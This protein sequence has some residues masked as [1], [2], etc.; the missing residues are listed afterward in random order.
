[1]IHLTVAAPLGIDSIFFSF[2]Q[3]LAEQNGH[4]C[5]NPPAQQLDEREPGAWIEAMKNSRQHHFVIGYRYPPAYWRT[6][7][8]SASTVCLLADPDGIARQVQQIHQAG[9]GAENAGD[10]RGSVLA[11]G[12]ALEATIGLAEW[13]LA[14]KESQTR[15]LPPASSFLAH[16]TAAFVR[17][18]QFYQQASIKI[19]TPCAESFSAEALPLLEQIQAASGDVRGEIHRLLTLQDATPGRLE[20]VATLFSHGD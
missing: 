4:I 11:I 5:V 20:A 3:R 13:I 16:S 17:F 9:E 10:L 7:A 19:A 2:V 18:E 12:H 6:L 8:E 1:M 15:I 14:D